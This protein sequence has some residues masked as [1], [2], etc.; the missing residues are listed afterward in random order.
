MSEIDID[1][2]RTAIHKARGYALLGMRYELPENPKKAM[3]IQGEMYAYH[4][5]LRLL[6]NYERDG[7]W[8]EQMEQPIS[9]SYENLSRAVANADNLNEQ[10]NGNPMERGVE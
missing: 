8:P 5:M 10:R 3:S 4:R 2:L 9:E 6:Q 1:E 7:H